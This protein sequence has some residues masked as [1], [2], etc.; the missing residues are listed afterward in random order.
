MNNYLTNCPKCGGKMHTASNKVK[1]VNCGHTL[2]KNDHNTAYNDNGVNYTNISAYRKKSPIPTAFAT[3]GFLVLILLICIAFKSRVTSAELYP[4]STKA[5]N[6][7][8]GN[9]NISSEEEE[10]GSNKRN[11]DDLS[12]EEGYCD[13]TEFVPQSVSL[14]NLSPYTGMPFAEADYPMEDIFSTE[15]SDC[16]FSSCEQDDGVSY[17]TYRLNGQ[18]ETF[19]FWSGI[20]SYGRGDPGTALIVVYGDNEVLYEKE[21]VCDTDTEYVCLSIKNVNDLTIEL[22]GYSESECSLRGSTALWPAL[23]EPTLYTQ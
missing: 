7:N 3:L 5:T 21:L 12:D 18:Y 9:Y 19:E 14:L 6:E 1:C 22:Y 15:F 8:N 2:Y 10:N 4:T 11:N 16:I 23:F 17:A 20:V 13:Y